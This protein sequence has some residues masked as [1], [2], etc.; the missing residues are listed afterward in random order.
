MFAQ[1]L[2][3]LRT[4]RKLSQQDLADIVGK[5]QQAVNLWE[6]GENEPGLETLNILAT[7]F[8]VSVDYL[9][10]RTDVPNFNKQDATN[11]ELTEPEIKELLSE[12]VEAINQAAKEGIISD[13]EKVS[14]V[15]E[16]VKIVE[17]E[18]YKRLKT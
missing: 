2:R 5:T 17:Y 10:C 8:G 14:F 3:E 13:E 15:K 11:L 4:S 16:A 6:K 18:L 9:M 7:F 12:I 1:R